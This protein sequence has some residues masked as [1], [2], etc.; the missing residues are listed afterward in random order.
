MG[1]SEFNEAL[2][3]AVKDSGAPGAVGYVGHGGET[4]FHEAVGMRTLLP[5]PEA[6]RRDTIYDLASLTKVIA[7]A[8]SVLLLHER[9]L[10]DLDR[11]VSEI[12]PLP[13]FKTITPRHLLTHTAGLPPFKTWHKEAG[14]VDEYIQR[15]AALPLESAPGEQR[16]YSDLG[17]MMLGRIVEI[18]GKNAL[19]SFAQEN[20]FKP[21]GMEHTGFNIPAAWRERC[22]ATEQCPW[23]GKLMRGE[24]HDE[25]AYAVGGVSGHAGL[26]APAGDLARFCRGLL[27]GKLLKPE[28]IA[29]M[30]RPGAVARYPWQV[31][32][33]KID[34]W[35]EG[36]E[37]H[38][39]S[40]R[41]IGHTGWTGT[42]LW[43]DLDS[44]HFVILLSNTPHPTRD[45]RDNATLRRTFHEPV[46][47][48]CHPVTTNAHTGLDRITWDAFDA[49]KGKRVAVLANHG[50][51]D[52]AGRPLLDVLALASEV[53]VVRV[54]S[55]E[56][57]FSGQAE[58]GENVGVQR[59]PIPLVSL[60]GDQK[61]PTRDQLR[62]VDLLLVDLPDIGARYY[63]YMATMKDCMEVC[64]EAAVPVM[65]LDRP[66][67]LGGA[68]LEGPIATSVGSLVCCAPI[69][70]RHGMTLGE[71]AM[72]FKSTFTSCAAVDLSV[73][74]LNAWPRSFLAPQCALP[75][76]PPSPNIP[77]FESALLY[78]G[79]CLFEGVNLNEGRGTDTPFQVLG[80]PWLD[81]GK[82]IGGIKKEDQRGCRLEA[83]TYT[84]RAIPGKASSP[85]YRDQNCNGIRIHLERAAD[86]R[87]FRLACALLRAIQ[88]THEKN[89]EW[90]PFF[91]TLAGG[92]AL[93]RAIQS[94]IKTEDYVQS[95]D[96]ELARFDAAR[97]RRYET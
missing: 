96:A 62:D 59:A 86:A 39:R 78:I 91:D 47:A 74:E 51:I 43:L 28:T 31:L 22:A 10:L 80:A 64:A 61:K 57:G 26:F 45:L 94:G 17:F 70:V 20:I 9:G 11:P 27:G 37:G 89:L 7:T 25:N 66:N 95:L 19:D 40:R 12:L 83:I 34:P 54:F 36:S 53:T 82:V 13:A 16:V 71:L 93:R 56:H 90:K 73:S 79:T 1:A 85:V 8:T 67:P 46:A 6:A 92:E 2:E 15:I 30:A 52:L 41:A 3:R 29:M 32:G 60:Y 84:P 75:W 38:L 4:L 76:V 50:A 33:W 55:P 68:I 69:P 23:R 87:P 5:E 49:L 44:H 81:A 58:A 18:I 48:A 35:A 97:P 72:F 42:S 14:S 63:T 24:V 88:Q 65:V 77:T 21:L